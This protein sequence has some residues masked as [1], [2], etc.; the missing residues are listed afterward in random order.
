MEEISRI[1]SPV[2]EEQITLHFPPPNFQTTAIHD[3]L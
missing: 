1:N 3:L 2:I